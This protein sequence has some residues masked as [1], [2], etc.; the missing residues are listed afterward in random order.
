MRPQRIPV[1]MEGV[2]FLGL[3]AFASVLFAMLGWSV[4]AVAAFALLVFILYF[5][6]DPH[7]VVPHGNDIL[8]SPADG[9]VLEVVEVD[10]CPFR[11]ARLWRV[12]IFMNIFNVHVNR[13]PVAGVVRNIQY[14]SGSFMPADRERAMVQN[15]RNAILIEDEKGRSVTVVQVAGLIARRIVCRAET[16]DWVRRGQRFGMIRFGSR[17]DCYLPHDCRMSV[18][19]GQRTVAGETVIAMWNKQDV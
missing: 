3:A 4:P 13:I 14:V 17:L 12:S 6:R 16:G 15:E 5:F 8:V 19:S 10:G 7:R 11:S 18:E 9:R 2:P 1:A